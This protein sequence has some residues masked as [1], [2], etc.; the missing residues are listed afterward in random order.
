MQTAER[1]DLDMA[2]VLL[3]AYELGDMINQSREVAEYLKWK[4]IVASSEDIQSKIRI[5]QKKKELFEEC[6]RFGHFHPEYHR[7]LEEV[8][9]AEKELDQFEAVRKYKEAENELDTL[10]YDMSKIIAHAVSDSIK[11]PS[12]NPLPSEGGCGAGGACRCG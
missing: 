12:N 8:K 10:L 6:E 2:Q 3:T 5:L 11:V 1:S 7:A 9:S 4:K